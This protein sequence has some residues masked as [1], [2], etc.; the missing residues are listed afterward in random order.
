MS[1]VAVIG[2]GRMGLCTRQGARD[3]RQERHRLE[4]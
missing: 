3:F 2:L 4:S 1:D